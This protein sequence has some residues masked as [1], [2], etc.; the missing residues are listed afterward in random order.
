[1][2]EAYYRPL[3]PEKAPAFYLP[4]KKLIIITADHHMNH[5]YDEIFNIHAIMDTE[6]IK[7]RVSE[8]EKN[9]HLY[10]LLIKNALDKLAET[11]K[12]HDLLEAFYVNC[13]DFEGVDKC[14]EKVFSGL[15]QVEGHTGT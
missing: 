3:S 13:M 11:K 4:E 6:G 1:M 14:F 10:D 5:E 9:L 12:L 7:T 8:I 2:I 15:A